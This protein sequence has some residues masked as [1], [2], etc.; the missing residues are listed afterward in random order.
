MSFTYSSE[1]Q[2]EL[3]KFLT[4]ERLTSYLIA[5]KGDIP[6]AIRL[7]ERNTRLSE[8]LYGVL[9]G[10]EV[11]IRN[12]MHLVLTSGMGTPEWYNKMNFGH[13]EALMIGDAKLNVARFR[14]KAT[15]G[16]IVSEL[17]MGF[18][19]RLLAPEYE[20]SLWVPHL[21]KAFPR[22]RRPDRI[23][24]FARIDE[25]RRL[26]NRIAHHEPIFK[27]DQAREYAKIIEA[28]E[29]ICPVTAAWVDSTSTFP[30]FIHSS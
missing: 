2:I 19:V 21:H 16:Q 25:I 15:P 23:L 18:W 12:S 13:R 27:K 29:W 7:Y 3:A 17:T 4:T 9:Q 6:S 5:T 28:I 10:C 11:A 14:K 30:R 26:R 8:S 24:I 20:K 22:Y 1:S